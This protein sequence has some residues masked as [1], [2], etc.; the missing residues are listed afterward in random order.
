MPVRLT[1]LQ[2]LTS[3]SG[4][5]AAHHLPSTAS[6][7]PPTN[8]SSC[9]LQRRMLVELQTYIPVRWI[10]TGKFVHLDHVYWRS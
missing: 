3:A 5:T 6:L 8:S 2:G 10:D 1:S 9:N 4:T 7:G